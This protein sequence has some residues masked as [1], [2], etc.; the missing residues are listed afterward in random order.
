MAGHLARQD[1][2]GAAKRKPGAIESAIL[3]ADAARAVRA[4]AR[5]DL[6]RWHRSAED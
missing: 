4:L 5:R 2:R 3:A 6:R 1:R